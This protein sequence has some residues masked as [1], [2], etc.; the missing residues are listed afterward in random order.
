MSYEPTNWK[1]GD[2]VTSAKLNKLEN[3]VAGNVLIINETENAGRLT[4]DKTWEEIYNVLNNG[5]IAMV[6]TASSSGGIGVGR[7][8][9]IV[10][11]YRAYETTNLDGALT[12]GISVGDFTTKMIKLYT[13]ESANEYPSR[14]AGGPS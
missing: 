12:Y 9:N 11:V 14:S 10:I 5:G 13:C 8:I 1:T 4:L 2:V 6:R 3:G 7:S